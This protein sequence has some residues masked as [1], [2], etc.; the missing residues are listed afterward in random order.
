[1]SNH[2]ETLL[3]HLKA[4]GSVSAVEARKVLEADTKAVSKL[5]KGLVKEGA[6]VR[7]GNTKGTRYT[8]A[9]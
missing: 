5:L 1:M 7:S 8:L 9:A 4:A 6:V 2:R 3:N